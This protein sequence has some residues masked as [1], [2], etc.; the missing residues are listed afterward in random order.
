M[1]MER[2]KI[3]KTMKTKPTQGELEA[4]TVLSRHFHAI[5]EFL[6]P[7]NGY[8]QKTPDILVNGVPWEIK[9]PIGGTRNTIDKQLKKGSRQ[10]RN[11]VINGMH[12]GIPDDVALKHLRALM[13]FRRRMNQVVYITRREEVVVVL[14]RK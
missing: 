12:I 14:E 11:I 5:V 8:K 10:A 3:P 7:T 9:V 6:E 2:V 4:A 1:M 13:Q